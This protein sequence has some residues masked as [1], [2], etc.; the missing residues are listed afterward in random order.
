MNSYPGRFITAPVEFALN[1]I[2]GNP[3]VR[4]LALS[5]LIT[6]TSELKQ[7]LMFI[8]DKEASVTNAKESIQQPPVFILSAGWGAG[9]TLV[10]RLVISGGAN[11][12]WGEPLD[13]AAPIQ[14]LAQSISAIRE[15]FPPDA[16][17]TDSYLSDTLSKAWIAN[18]V[19]PME[20]YREAHREF[21][22]CWL[23]HSTANSTYTGWGLK[24]VRLTIDHA[25]YL[26]WLYPN[27]RIIFVYRDLYSCY[28]SCRR[29]PWM[30]V[31]PDHKATPIIAFAHHWN[32]L[33]G[34]FVNGCKDVNG[35]LIR[36]EDLVNGEFQLESLKTFL[37]VDSI[38][39][40]LLEQK[41]GGRSANRRP[42]ILPEKLILDGIA[43]R[44]RSELG[45][46][47]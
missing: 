4:D 30:S 34:G 8:G 31:W 26:K 46:K 11:L 18:L 17:F 37:D 33:L 45:Y 28:L 5:P 12:I 42:L 21:L 44:L 41:V 14:R 25:R 39:E 16:H 9:S 6:R 27:A 43:G 15:G 35:L 23:S 32:H 20:R 38:D 10:Q 24:E 40:N 36:Y 13:Q 3:F 22:R 1:L 2:L 29:K 7:A 47:K 19:P